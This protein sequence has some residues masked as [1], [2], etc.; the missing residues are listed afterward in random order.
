MTVL[1]IAFLFFYFPP[2]SSIFPSSSSPSNAA[3]MWAHASPWW[4]R[5][6]QLH[7]HWSWPLPHLS[8]KAEPSNPL[9]STSCKLWPAPL[10]AVLA[11]A[12]ATVADTPPAAVLTRA[13]AAHT[14]TDVPAAA[15]AAK[16]A[17]ASVAALA[18]PAMAARLSDRTLQDW[19]WMRLL[20]SRSSS[21]A[22]RCPR[23]RAAVHI[24]LRVRQPSALVCRG[25]ARWP[26]ARGGTDWPRHRR[27]SSRG[28]LSTR[29][30]AELVF[31]QDGPTKRQ[32]KLGQATFF[33][34][35]PTCI[36]V[37]GG[38][39]QLHSWNYFENK[40]LVKKNSSQHLVKLLWAV[41][42][43]SLSISTSG[44]GVT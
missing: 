38:E 22:R 10:A 43:R 27:R 42:N 30:W 21:R 23:A 41:P 7:P 18:L 17:R 11:H 44:D 24:P 16:A 6:Q 15:L 25:G 4:L 31:T 40:C 2:L 37:R 39:K 32:V 29:A 19:H 3:R 13:A 12:P 35:H 1:P 34:L 5:Q 20:A 36:F 26:G 14:P 33:Q 9:R 28:W 8:D